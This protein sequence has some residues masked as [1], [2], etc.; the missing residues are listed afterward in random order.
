MNRPPIKIEN[1]CHMKWD[2]L[3]PLE[4]SKDRHCSECS[5]DIIDFRTMTNEEIIR[6]LAER[7][8]KRVCGALCPREKKADPMVQRRLK[9]W[10][11]GIKSR[12]GNHH[13]KSFLLFAIGIMMFAIGCEKDDDE[14]VIGVVEPADETELRAEV[15]TQSNDSIVLEIPKAKSGL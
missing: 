5:F 10:H 2:D 11:A 9:A 15:A 7:N 14:V 8:G 13:F 3:T 12:V 4:N 1:P 6:Y